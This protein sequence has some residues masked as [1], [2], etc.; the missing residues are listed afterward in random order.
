MNINVETMIRQ[1]KNFDTDWN[2]HFY[3]IEVIMDE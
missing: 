1:R 3:P 2:D